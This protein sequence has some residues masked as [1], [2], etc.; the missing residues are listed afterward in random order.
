VLAAQPVPVATEPYTLEGIVAKD[1]A[2]A[3]EAGWIPISVGYV[4]DDK[5]PVRWIGVTAFRTWNDDPFV[6][7]EDLRRILPSQPTLLVTGPPELVKQLK[8]APDGGRLVARGM[9]NKGS[10][11][12]MLSGVK[13]APAGATTGK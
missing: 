7:R 13:V 2:G 4:G 5:T 11:N 9:L 12:F 1:Q 6:G 8:E 3:R 10:R